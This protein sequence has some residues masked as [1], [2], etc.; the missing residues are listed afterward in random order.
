[1]IKKLALFSLIV[2]MAGCAGTKTI[3]LSADTAPLMEGRMMSGAFADEK[4]GFAAMTADKAM[5]GALGAVAMISAG[6]KIIEE[7]GVEDP[8][9][10]IYESLAPVLAE[11]YSLRLLD[12]NSIRTSSVKPADLADNVNDARL[13]LDVRTIGWNMGYFPT[14]WNRY[15]VGYSAKLRLIDTSTQEVLAESVCSKMST[16]E[17]ESAP[18]YDELMADQAALL[19][20]QLLSAADHCVNEFKT[21]TLML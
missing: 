7:N 2:F 12:D 14:V 6:N 1:M 21:N 18:T 5:F 10:Y 4:P 19:K 16:D 13:L 8:A 3:P 9:S 11:Q 20:S 15:R 17:S